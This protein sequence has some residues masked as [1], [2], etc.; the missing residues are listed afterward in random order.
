MG[1]TGPTRTISRLV[2][3]LP[4]LTRICLQGS[5]NPGGSRLSPREP[6]RSKDQV[7]ELERRTAED[8]SGVGGKDTEAESRRLVRTKGSRRPLGLSA[9]LDCGAGAEN[10]I[11]VVPTRDEERRPRE[12]EP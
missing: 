12:A 1:R 9:P 11:T 7:A 8:R 5:T 2:L 6:G 10:R 4:G 3:T